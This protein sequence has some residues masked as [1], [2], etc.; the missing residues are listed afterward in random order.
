K[1]GFVRRVHGGR[2]ARF[3]F[4]KL[5]PKVSKMIDIDKWDALLENLKSYLNTRIELLKLQMTDKLASASS[6]VVAIVLLVLASISCIFFF[7]CWAALYLSSKIGD[8][9]SGFAIVGGLYLVISI[10]LILGRKQILVTPLRNQ[11]IKCLF[12]NED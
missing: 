10:I 8:T 2:L 9:Y 6:S 4:A 7:S 1:R 11:I 3:F 12:K 5:T